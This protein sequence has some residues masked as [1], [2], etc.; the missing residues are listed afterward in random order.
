MMLPPGLYSLILADPPWRFATRSDKGLSKSPQ[1]HYDCMSLDDIKALPVAEI[2][3]PD[4][5]LMMW[6]TAP[7]LP[8]ALEV[9][10]AWGF[11]FKTMG[12]WAKQSKTGRKWAFGTGYIL[13][14]A[15]EPFII[16]TRGNPKTAT[17][18]IRNLIVAPVREHSRKPDCAR[19]NLEQ[20]IPTGR[21]LEMFARESAE[22]WDAW[23]NETGKFDRHDIREAAE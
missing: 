10:T 5:L 16:G 11:A 12:A 1:A 23:G 17:K 22:G 15:S 3:A 4:C 19:T 21:R 18:S 6:A 14:S 9:M 2:A 8:Q 20:M 7:M 13:R